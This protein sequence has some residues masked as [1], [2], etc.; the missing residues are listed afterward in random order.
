MIGVPAAARRLGVSPGRV[1]QRISDGSLP[2]EWVGRQWVIDERDLAPLTDLP[3]PGRPLSER[4]AWALIALSSALANENADG[5]AVRWIAALPALDRSRARKRLRNLLADHQAASDEGHAAESAAAL[6]SLVGN[7]ARR[8]LLR[9][10]PRDLDDVRDDDR[11]VRAGLSDPKAGIAS[12]DLV[13]GYAAGRDLSGIVEDYLL[14]SV[15]RDE[16]ANVVLHVVA[17]DDLADR[18]L[19]LRR[20]EPMVHLLLAAD[21]AEHGRPRERARAVGLVADLARMLDIA[22]TSV[23]EPVRD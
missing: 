3:G 2:A 8:V 1:R 22:P 18:A 12:G 23:G 16:G 15:D 10:S 4:S 20:S 5:P 6:R 7:R 11:I 21:L 17:D 13:E 19:A 9:A 14:D